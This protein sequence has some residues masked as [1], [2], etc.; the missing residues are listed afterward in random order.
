MGSASSGTL[1]PAGASRRASNSSVLGR[2]RRTL[3]R[4]A[5]RP[6]A[7]LD[8]LVN[9]VRRAFSTAI[10]G[11][12]LTASA[13]LRFD[14]LAPSF[15]YGFY[16]AQV[17]ARWRGRPLEAASQRELVTDRAD[18]E[19]IDRQLRLILDNDDWLRRQKIRRAEP[20]LVVV[21]DERQIGLSV[22]E[23]PAAISV[24]T[25]IICLLL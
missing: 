3:R 8:I 17:V 25:F 5:S 7:R 2:S 6:P 1:Q 19:N 12:A 20:S 14:H 22:S 9:R 23:Q 21:P 11:M 4:E 10:K 24:E 18:R 13:G 15:R 16:M